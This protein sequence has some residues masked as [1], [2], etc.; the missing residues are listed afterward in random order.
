MCKGSTARQICG[1]TG[2][3]DFLF[4]VVTKVVFVADVVTGLVNQLVG[5]E[6]TSEKDTDAVHQP[7]FSVLQVSHCLKRKL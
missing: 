1:L 2:G 5:H 3:G 6:E 7:N 4:L